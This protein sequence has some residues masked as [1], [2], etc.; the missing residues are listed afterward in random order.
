MSEIKRELSGTAVYFLEGEHLERAATLNITYVLQDTQLR[1]AVRFRGHQEWQS[2]F[3]VD[4]LFEGFPELW[5]L[6]AFAR[7]HLCQSMKNRGCTYRS[8]D[9]R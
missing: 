1:G 7:S 3:T 8:I 6:K 5:E 2:N 9:F 4:G